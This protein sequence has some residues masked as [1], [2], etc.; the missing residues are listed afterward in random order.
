MRQATQ[1]ALLG[2]TLLVGGCNQQQPAAN[3]DL[4]KGLDQIVASNKEI[5]AAT[6]D[7]SGAAKSTTDAVKDLAGRID[8]LEQTMAAGLAKQKRGALYLALDDDAACDNDSA[9]V[10]TARAI[11]N[12]VDYPNGMA[13]KVI[14]GVRPTLHSL[15]CFD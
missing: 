8:K 3:E 15:V 10:N 1:A 5:A 14:A 9:C 13:S 4:K 12:K 11:C 6:K 2:L 7:T